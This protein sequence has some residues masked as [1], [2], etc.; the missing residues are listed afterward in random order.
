M[1]GTN[2]HPTE[3]DSIECHLQKIGMG[4]LICQAARQTSSKTT[5]EVNPKIC[6]NCPAGK[7]YREVGC[8]AVLPKISLSPVYGGPIV[9]IESLFC[10]IRKRETNLEYCQTCGLV[11]AE[12]TR[13]IVT[14]ARGLFQAQGFYSAYQDLEKARAAI[15]DGNFASAITHSIACLESTMRI[16]HDQLNQPLPNGKQMTDLWKSTR[17]LLNLDTLDVSGASV[18]LANTLSGVAFQLGS[19]RNALSDAHGRGVTPPDVSES[20]AELAI[21]VAATLSTLII[22]RFNQMKGQIE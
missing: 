16:C 2:L 7:I 1:S 20:I 12:T 21:N 6:F 5:N 10:K 19:L 3:N 22:R 18:S 17:T 4:T 8:D 13:Q 14:T 15:R 11:T 9:R